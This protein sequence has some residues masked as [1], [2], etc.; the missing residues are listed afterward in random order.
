MGNI[1]RRV[2]FIIREEHA[3]VVVLS[4]YFFCSRFGAL[5]RCA[6]SVVHI[7][8]HGQIAAG[9]TEGRDG[10]GEERTGTFQMKNV[11][12]LQSVGCS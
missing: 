7:L 12:P 3:T 9:H 2:L 5:R 10:E 1:V 6:V 11:C 8:A 4:C